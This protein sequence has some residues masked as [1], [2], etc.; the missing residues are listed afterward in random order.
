MLL[1]S[2]LL[3]GLQIH[4]LDAEAIDESTSAAVADEDAYEMFVAVDAE[5]M[6]P[7]KANVGGGTKPGAP[8]G[9]RTTPAK[10]PT[11]HP[12]GPPAGVRGARPHLPIA[13]PPKP[14]GVR[15]GARVP[16]KAVK[17]PPVKRKPVKLPPTAFTTIK[18]RD[19]IKAREKTAPKGVMQQLA[20][21]RKT[22]GAKKRRFKVGYTKAL[23]IPIAQLTGL[24][25]L[26]D[27]KQL[28]LQ[29][30]QNEIARSILERRGVRGIPNF[31]QRAVR[32]PKAI[33]PDAAVG[34]PLIVEPENKG[35]GKSSDNVENPL[36]PS[37][38]DV[39]CSPNGTAWSWKEYLAPPRSQ[40]SCGSCWAFAT[41]GVFEGA[42]AIA[43]GFDKTL[44]FSEQY[45]VDC[46]TSDRL[47]GDI[48]D[49]RGGYT[50]F[51]Y[52]WLK[53]KG[54]ALEGEVPYLN[55]DGQC[56]AKLKPSHKIA[57]WGFVNE[58]KIIPEV[59]EIKAALC[60]YGPLSASVYATPS[61]IAYT[62]GVF[63]EGASGQP[64]HAIVIAGWDD[65]RGAWLVRNSWDTF[66]GED[67][68]IWVKYGSNNI[69]TGAAWAMVESNKPEP[70]TVTFKSRQL[71]V[72]NKT[73]GVL[74]V[75]L[76]YKTGKKWLPGK[77]SA[78]NAI[79][80]SVADG[81]EALLGDGDI[82][83]AASE[84]RLWAEGDGGSG[85]WTKYKSKSLDLTPKGSYKGTA[86]DTFVYTF[87]QSNADAGGKTTPTKGKAPDDAF[88]EAYAAFDGGDYA[89]SGELFSAFLSTYP[90][91]ARIPE[92][93]FWLGYG[94]YMQSEFYEALMEWYEVV[95][96]YP[97]NDFVAYALYYSGLAYVERG[98]CDLALQCY[99]LVAHAGY[100]A[101][102]KEWQ[103]AALEQIK[104]LDKGKAKA[105]G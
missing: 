3:L 4:A 21:M 77:P 26:P 29:R 1:E 28:E 60:K 46:A 24:K 10:P 17:R 80:F 62:E 84:V 98:E 56:N 72:R 27:A 94:F 97:E 30:K 12:A 5:T 93:R 57:A 38:G 25:S 55:A 87:D 86:I 100:P 23:D 74:K 16:G 75:Q 79:A 63:D 76:Q 40:K 68:Y 105:C 44:D 32:P 69:G 78:G 6:A 99:D 9:M 13:G 36:Q 50:P 71:S 20:A 2:L 47:P 95:V 61:F 88:N 103:D 101:A 104:A 67:G 45:I 34:S 66:W 7:V 58:Q 31:M 39:V 18:N 8:T 19:A 35:K 82:P 59:D 22:I 53:D 42:S 85:T 14:G 41:L 15:P 11:G 52:D 65:L 89:K 81:A 91:S 43:N 48:G 54:A 73:G 51:V 83:V 96:N 102:T 70:K 64:N 33:R 90:G 49:C 92:V 37:V